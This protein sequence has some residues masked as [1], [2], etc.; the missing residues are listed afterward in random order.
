MESKDFTK[1]ILSTFAQVVR[2]VTFS[3]GNHQIMVQSIVETTLSVAQAFRSSNRQEPRLDNEG[4]TSFLI[5]KEYREY[6]N[7]DGNKKKQ[8]SLPASVLR[9]INKISFTSW[10]KSITHLLI[11]ALFFAM[12]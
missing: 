11:L 2:E 12:R 8:K 3:T 1:I 5:K 7:N 10:K 9:R 4:K 6:Q